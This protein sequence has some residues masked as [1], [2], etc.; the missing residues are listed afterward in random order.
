MKKRILLSSFALTSLIIHAQAP[1]V[2]ATQ[3]LSPA[4][5]QENMYMVRNDAIKTLSNIFVMENSK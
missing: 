3:H 2:D 5:I 4:A 1:A